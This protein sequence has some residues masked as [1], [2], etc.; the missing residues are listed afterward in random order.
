LSCS[1]WYFG[2]GDEHNAVHAGSIAEVFQGR[3]MVR[4]SCFEV[5]DPELAGILKKEKELRLAE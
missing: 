5:H 1:P 4:K 2:P 3:F